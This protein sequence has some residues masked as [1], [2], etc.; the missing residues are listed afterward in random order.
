MECTPKSGA[1]SISGSNGLLI[2]QELKIKCYTLHAGFYMTEQN[3]RYTKIPFPK[4]RQPIADAL[5]QAVVFSTLPAE[6]N[7]EPAA[8][9]EAAYRL[10][11]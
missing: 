1:M 3:Q 11:Q 2:F 7:W 10:S 9:S 8:V 4:V 6:Q 5:R